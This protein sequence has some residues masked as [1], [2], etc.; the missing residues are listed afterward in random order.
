VAPT[1]Q[2]QARWVHSLAFSPDGR[3][4]AS[5]GDDGTARLWDAAGVREV[6]TLK[7]HTGKVLG[8][9]WRH[10]GK[11]LASAGWDGTLRL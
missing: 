2:G 9:A 3:R 6:R 5:A 11:R 10:D 8:V 1:G 4:L 7:G